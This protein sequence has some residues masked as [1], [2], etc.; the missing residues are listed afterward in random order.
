L[1]NAAISYR[2][3]LT[4]GSYAWPASAKQRIGQRLRTNAS[5][6]KIRGDSR[7]HFD[8]RNGD[9]SKATQDHRLSRGWTRR[10]RPGAYVSCGYA[11]IRP[12]YAKAIAGHV[13][14]PEPYARTLAHPGIEIE[15]DV[16]QLMNKHKELAALLLQEPDPWSA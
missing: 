13:I 1:T 4:I 8:Q 5:R 7:P 3:H 9:D 14:T 11:T 2:A 16:K 10:Y 12:D 15:D 6:L